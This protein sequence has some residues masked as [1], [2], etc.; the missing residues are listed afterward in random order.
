MTLPL[1]PIYGVS[2]ASAYFLLGTPDG[3]EKGERQ[4]VIL[5]NAERKWARYAL[6][7]LFTFLIPSA[8]EL[9]VGAFFD[10]AFALS[11]WDY[12]DMPLNI[13][14]YVCAPISL[15]W[16]GMLFLFMKY[17]FMPLKN[18]V[19]KLPKLI[20]TVL[21]IVLNVGGAIDLIVNFAR[22]I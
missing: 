5:Q 15:A 6:Y 3:A 8:A 21:A 11:L 9:L 10:G 4:G 20:S 1:C 7:L 12:S 19:G 2:I 14:G 22:L 17:L 16:S 18:F 13:R